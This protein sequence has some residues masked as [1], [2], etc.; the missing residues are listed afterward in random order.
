MPLR[1]SFD[2]AQDMAQ[3]EPLRLSFD[4][5]Q[6]EAQGLAVLRQA[7][8]ELLAL[9]LIRRTLLL[10]HLGQVRSRGTFLSYGALNSCP[11][12]RHLKGASSIFAFLY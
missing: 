12:R 4:A 1:Q 7:Q 2:S 3:G 11:Q 6:D 9:A 10:L 5:A 8:D